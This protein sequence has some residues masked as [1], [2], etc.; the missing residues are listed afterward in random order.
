MLRHGSSG[1]RSSLALL[2][3]PW[4]TKAEGLARATS[5][6]KSAPDCIRFAGVRPV[7]GRDASA[8]LPRLGSWAVVDGRL[9]VKGRGESGARI[10][11]MPTITETETRSS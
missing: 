1:L 10:P 7:C 3:R 4:M 6:A 5:L 9:C 11:I 2:L 8:A